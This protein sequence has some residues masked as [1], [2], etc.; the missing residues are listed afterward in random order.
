[1]GEGTASTTV[2]VV[3]RRGGGCGDNGGDD[4][5]KDVLVLAATRS[6]VGQLDEIGWEEEEDVVTTAAAMSSHR[7]AVDDTTRWGGADVVMVRRTMT[8]HDG[9]G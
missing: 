5:G 2:D 3:M 7:G 4:A 9:E 8:T 6:G 1:M